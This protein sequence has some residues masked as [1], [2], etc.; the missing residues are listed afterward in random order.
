MLRIMPKE[1]QKII[2]LL[3]RMLAVEGCERKLEREGTALGS[4][5]SKGGSMNH[6]Q[7]VFWGASCHG[8]GCY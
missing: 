6:D 7:A 5:I 1:D 2:I 8:G 4:E 3:L